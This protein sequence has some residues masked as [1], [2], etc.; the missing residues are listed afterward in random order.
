MHGLGVRQDRP[1]LDRMHHIDPANA[2]ET[3]GSFDFDF[4]DVKIGLVEGSFLMVIEGHGLHSA[5]RMNDLLLL[6]P[7]CH[8]FNR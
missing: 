4:I 6:V 7:V 2:L 3:S 5:G 1:E 8:S